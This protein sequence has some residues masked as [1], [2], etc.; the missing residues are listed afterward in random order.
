MNASL[1]MRECFFDVQQAW[2]LGASKVGGKAFQLALLRR[3]GLPVPISFVIPAD[4]CRTLLP[5]PLWRDAC[6]ACALLDTEKYAA[7]ENI[8]ERILQHALPM[9]FRVALSEFLTEQKWQTQALAV[10][11]SAPGEDSQ[12]HSFAG[13]HSSELNVMG[14][15]AIEQAILKVIASLWTVQACAYREKIKLQHNDAAMAIVLMPMLQSQV[16]GVIFTC[17]PRDGR[18]DRLLISSVRG[19]AESLVAGTVDGE[20]IMVQRDW[21]CQDWRVIHRRHS[22]AQ[23]A[24]EADHA[25]GVR[26]RELSA[27]EK[28]AETL[29]NE[30]A[31]EL[32]KLAIDTANAFDYS[33]RFLDIEWVFDGRQFYLVQARPISA[34]N[35]YTYPQISDQSTAWTNGNTKEILP[36]PLKISELDVMQ[37]AVN[38]MLGV[39][40]RIVGVEPLEGGQRSA[41]F[42][43]YAY[44][45]A[46]LIQW[47]IYQTFNFSPEEMNFIL[48]GHQE[49]IKV[50]ARPVREY[51]KLSLNL[52]KAILRFP[53]YRKRGMKEA[54][55]V[56]SQ[57]KQWRQQDIT[58]LTD[59][60]LLD[61]L[62]D[63]ARNTY[64][65]HTGLC[66]MQ[67]ASGTLMNMQKMMVS[68]FA[69]EGK[70]LVSAI[71]SEGEM[72]ISAKQA[73]EL[74]KLAKLAANETAAQQWLSSENEQ[75][76]Y[77]FE[78]SS[79]FKHAY[80]E[81]LDQFGHRGNYESYISRP[82][83]REQAST[84]KQAILSLAQVDTQ[85][86]QER[87]L[88][89][90]EWAWKKIAEKT[91]APQRWFLRILQKQAKTECNQRELARS[92]FAMILERC[93]T[94]MLEIARRL[95]ERG[96]LEQAEDVFHLNCAELQAIH[97]QTLSVAAIGN[98]ILDRKTQLAKWES[99][100]AQDVIYEQSF[101]AISSQTPKSQN[102]LQRKT[103]N[104]SDNSWQGIAVS[105]GSYQ[106]KVR[107]ITHP[108][109]IGQLQQG[110]I[111]LAASSDPSWL[112]LFLK[113]GG[114]IVETGG[115]LSHSAIVAR[116]LAIPTV[117]NL[118]GILAILNDGDEV[119]IDGSSGTVTRLS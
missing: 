26:Q 98:R 38:E 100:E 8:R 74:M 73:Y 119:M 84:L 35:I 63:R 42:N 104:K 85:A 97:L 111:M 40:H 9:D 106:G 59:Q 115:Y 93:R 110:E 20:D 96:M 1:T 43:G 52:L 78:A 15:A 3:Y 32:A 22:N 29:S 24:V 30:A 6:V 87:Q 48:G 117:V 90:A 16:A 99:C 33:Q 108:S 13:I 39:A 41:I 72:S 58:Q 56:F 2:E 46:S 109:Q 94:L 103:I 114:V 21:S 83:W 19:L 91:Y 77:S 54:A 102:K 50:P 82:A 75:S 76:L 64:L 51:A 27:Q 81:F 17:D 112:P 34:R 55:H 71:M 10:R 7:L 105:M 60:A 23:F 37:V 36:F 116:E 101:N 14:S 68:K 86:L 5:E 118:P 45:N 69:E 25:G 89:Q 70:T 4:V 49:P 95:V 31:I 12:Q 44:L 61:E 47:E 18:E 113:A 53:Q 65:T 92:S 67:G 11:S 62:L 66:I 57:S 28:N 80:I 88:Q 107:H 79:L